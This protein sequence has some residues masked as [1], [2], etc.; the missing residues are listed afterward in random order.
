MSENIEDHIFNKFEIIK[1]LG[2]GAYGV[3]WKAID[4]KSGRIIALKK[5]I[6]IKIQGIWC[7]S[8]CNWRIKNI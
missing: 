8:Q 5:V 7:I 1:K 6:F 4:R 2:K 3:V